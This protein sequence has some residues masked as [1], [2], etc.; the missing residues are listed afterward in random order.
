MEHVLN[1]QKCTIQLK[2][3]QFAICISPYIMNLQITS[4]SCLLLVIFDEISYEAPQY[5]IFS[6]LIYVTK[7]KVVHIDVKTYSGCGISLQSLFDTEMVSHTQ[8]LLYIWAESLV[9]T[10]LEAGWAPELVRMFQKNL[11]ILLGFELWIVQPAA[12]PL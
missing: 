5:I 9:P 11:L 7:G 2:K 8:Q 4:A 6:N 1:H 12:P 3:L 10:E